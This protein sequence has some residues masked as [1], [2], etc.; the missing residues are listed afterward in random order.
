MQ[1]V[2]RYGNPFFQLFVPC[3]YISPVAT[4]FGVVFCLSKHKTLVFFLAVVNHGRNPIRDDSARWSQHSASPQV[5]HGHFQQ[6]GGG[7]SFFLF[8][9]DFRG[10]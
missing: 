4:H 9:Y 6:V 8:L 1:A 7:R 3:G 5:C 10:I 2:F